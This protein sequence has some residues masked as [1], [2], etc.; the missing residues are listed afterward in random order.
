MNIFKSRP[1]NTVWKPVANYSDSDEREAYERAA[2]KLSID[3]RISYPVP[4][5][6]GADYCA[7]LGMKGVYIRRSQAEKERDFTT[8]YF[9]ELRAM[10]L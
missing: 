5:P 9:E 1:D 6:A 2:R 7:Q 8:S 4:A 3:I 10:S